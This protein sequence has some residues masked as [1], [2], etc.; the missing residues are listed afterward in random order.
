MKS[1]DSK[2]IILTGG[3]TAGHVIPN[4]ALF[5]HLTHQCDILYIGST[6]GIE[7]ELITKRGI[8]YKAISSG[9]LRRYFDWKNFTDPFRILKG[10]FQSIHHIRKFKPHVIFSK[11]GFVSVPVILAGALLRIP[12]IAHE[13]DIT[14][15]LA[16][17]ITSPFAKKVCTTFLETTSYLPAKKALYT[18]SPTRD[19]L[20]NGNKEKGYSFTGLSSSLPIVL[21]MGGSLGSVAINRAIRNS[22]TLLTKDM[23]IIHLCGKGNIDPTISNDRYVQYEYIDNELCDVFSITDFIISRAGS[24][25]INEFLFLEK[26]SLLIPLSKSASRGDQ[27]INAK[28]FEKQ[29]YS[30]VLEEENLTEAS[31][32][33]KTQELIASSATIKENIRKSVAKNGTQNVLEEIT[34]FLF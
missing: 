6:N 2:R 27:I 5:P 12:I 18:G 9:K 20:K 14:P 1:I 13:S 22:L 24:N 31:L 17:K 4:L 8:S 21:V 3:G 7:K 23:Q 19:S 34:K 29:G 32:L 16:T 25:S 33:A 10:F 30:L 26:P 28:S 11:G 15:G